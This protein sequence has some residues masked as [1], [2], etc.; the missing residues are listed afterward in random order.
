MTEFSDA[1]ADLHQAFADPITYTGAGLNGATITGT[2]YDVAGDLFQGAGSTAR[3]VWF[4][5]QQGD[6]PQAPA[7][8][9]GVRHT[10]P[11]TG[12]TT[13]WS[14]IDIA[15]RDDIGAFDLTVEKA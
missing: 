13:D 15:R 1:A 11:M 5:I 7:K 8:R 6:L 4:E 3:R 14:V 12:I 9:N 2:K 10:D